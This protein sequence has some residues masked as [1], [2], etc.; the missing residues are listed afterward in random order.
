MAIGPRGT[1]AAAIYA[2]ARPPWGTKPGGIGGGEWVVVYVGV[3]VIAL[4]V[5]SIGNVRVG[6]E[7]AAGDRVLHPPAHVVHAH[8]ETQR[9]LERVAL[10]GNPGR[11]CQ[12]RVTGCT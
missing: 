6:R 7:H 3:A 5:G 2:F 1:A 11:G 8:P 10:T 4:R 12:I 9:R